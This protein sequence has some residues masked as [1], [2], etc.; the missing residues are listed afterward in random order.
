MPILRETDDG[1]TFNELND[2]ERDEQLVLAN[3]P[4]FHPQHGTELSGDAFDYYKAVS[5][6]NEGSHWYVKRTDTDVA[7]ELRWSRMRTRTARLALYAF[8]RKQLWG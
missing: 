4:M 3:W 1:E 5:T 8:I 7:R 6:V 2:G